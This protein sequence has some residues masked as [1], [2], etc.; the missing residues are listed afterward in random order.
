MSVEAY[1]VLCMYAE[2]CGVE[3]GWK[4]ISNR[5]IIS[6]FSLAS[7]QVEDSSLKH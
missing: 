1:G 2:E 6:F 5:R 4:V 3:V 7:M